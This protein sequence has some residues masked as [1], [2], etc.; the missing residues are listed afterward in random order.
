[1]NS[2]T[3]LQLITVYI[4]EEHVRKRDRIYIFKVN[5]VSLKVPY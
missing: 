4:L 1:M 3:A 5:L 2:D